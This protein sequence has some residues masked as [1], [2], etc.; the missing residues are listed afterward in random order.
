MMLL[1]IVFIVCM[2]QIL[3]NGIQMH[4]YQKKNLLI[5]LMF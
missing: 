1:N 2:Q 4:K 5:C 3:G